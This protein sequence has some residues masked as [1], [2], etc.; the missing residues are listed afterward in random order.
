MSE[1]VAI[2]TTLEQAG[3]ITCSEGKLIAIDLKQNKIVEIDSQLHVHELHEL[4]EVNELTQDANLTLYVTTKYN[5][6]LKITRDGSIKTVGRHGNGNSE[7]DF[8]NGLQ[9]SQQ[10][11]L[12]VCDSNNHRVQVFDLDLNFKRTFGRKGSGK[13]QLSSPTDVDFD[14][15]G[16]I[17]VVDS[18]NNRIQVF[19]PNEQHIRAIGN[20]R[21]GST[22][23]K[24]PVGIRV[25][26]DHVYVTD[27]DNHRVL[28]MSLQG[29][30]ITILGKGHLKKP[31]GIAINQDGFVYVT[32]QNSKIVVF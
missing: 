29:E 3:A 14:S 31:E 15:S 21:S 2:I 6:L 30:V 24:Q 18:W 27:Y 7:F 1:P 32:S 5:L 16:C 13:E 19:T 28:V 20:Q 22:K 4:K 10:N 23:L 25:H 26:N 12:Y 17:Y 11:E 8:P 9:I